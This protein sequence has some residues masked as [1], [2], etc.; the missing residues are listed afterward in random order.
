M[1]RLKHSV[2]PN[3]PT[4]ANARRPYLLHADP[5]Q[6]H[7][8]P[9]QFPPCQA[10]DVPPRV[11]RKEPPAADRA[12]TESR[13]CVAHTPTAA[14][15]EKHRGSRPSA[16]DVRTIL[17]N[18]YAKT[19]CCIS[20]SQALTSPSTLRHELTAPGIPDATTSID[21][22]HPPAVRRRRGTILV[23][24]VAIAAAAAIAFTAGLVWS[25]GPG[26]GPGHGGSAFPRARCRSRSSRRQKRTLTPRTW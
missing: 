14:N 4:W 26:T 11:P 6:G 21:S 10:R 1:G 7:R 20:C 12:Q 3:N 18:A 5:L 23:G 17:A 19:L 16:V 25:N 22:V 8:S 24:A 13:L 2:P 9:D 15:F